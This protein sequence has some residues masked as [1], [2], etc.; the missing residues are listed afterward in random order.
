MT[1]AIIKTAN[2]RK[3]MTQLCKHWS[4]RFDIALDDATG[5]AQLPGGEVRFVADAE[6][7]AVE[8]LPK[9]ASA[10]PRMKEVVAEHL[11]RFAFRE[12]PLSLSWS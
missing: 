1:T 4:H 5:T 8:I 12:A 6:T 3:Y 2:A 9:D 7:L 11:N 10:L